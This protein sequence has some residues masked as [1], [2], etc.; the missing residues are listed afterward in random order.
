MVKETETQWGQMPYE[1]AKVAGELNWAQLRSVRLFPR[2][3]CISSQVLDALVCTWCLF[4]IYRVHGVFSRHTV[5]SFPSVHTA[6]T[7]WKLLILSFYLSLNSKDLFLKVS[8]CPRP[9]W[10]FSIS[11]LDSWELVCISS[12]SGPWGHKD[13]FGDT[14][15][16][17]NFSLDSSFVSSCYGNE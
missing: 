14:A 16:F 10:C 1:L 15:H 17:L 4:W 3:H 9:Q 12:I 6:H 13:L 5:Y 2:R 7:V 8:N 11:P